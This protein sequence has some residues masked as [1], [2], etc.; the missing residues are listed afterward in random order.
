MA[1][2]PVL[3]V[4][5]I[6]TPAPVVPATPAPPRGGFAGDAQEQMRLRL[7]GAL[8]SAFAKIAEAAPA[9]PAAPATQVTPPATSTPEPLPAAPPE[10]A[11]TAPVV[12]ELDLE[13]I[14]LDAV[15]APAT[16]P[17]PDATP[18]IG[19]REAWQ[20]LQAAVDAGEIPEKIETAF[21]RTPRGKQMLTSFKTNRELQKP[22]E[23]GGIGTVPTVEEIREG[24]GFR[25]DVRVM[26]HEFRDNPTGFASNVLGLKV[27][28]GG[29]AVDG[30]SSYFGGPAE[31][32]QFLSSLPKVLAQHA[33]TPTGQRLID[34]YA[35]PIFK[36]FL[37][38]QYQSALALPATT[39][40]EQNLKARAIDAL[41]M[42]EYLR[43]GKA[44]PLNGVTA[45]A[46]LQPG[47]VS[48]EV[49]ELRA[50]AERAEQLL[51]QQ[52]N[53]AQGALVNQ[54]KDASRTSAMT[55]INKILETTGLSKVYPKE[56]LQPLV[57]DL[58]KRIDD[59]VTGASGTQFDR[60]GYQTY[61]IQLADLARD[62]NP[63]KPAAMYQRIFRNVLQTHPDIK[64]QLTAL[65]HNAK[66]QSDAKIGQQAAAQVRTEPVGN[67]SPVPTSVLPNGLQKNPGESSAEFNARRLGA[68]L[69]RSGAIR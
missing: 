5:D 35:T 10:P 45:P 54:V 32:E 33:N 63:S 36:S 40:Q 23:D 4:P 21:L 16:E 42:T 47:E 11:I 28:Q 69:A 65:V 61:Q 38:T 20:Q 59:L 30:I 1:T 53:T 67:G 31:V 17:A 50:R 15:V 60:S 52:R 55:D 26:R 22:W 13:A 58:Y 19:D 3:P 34:A 27:D 51:N 57:Q 29:N 48:P 8:G 41:Q 56:L 12:A 18:A 49:T 44:R 62:P 14:D 37:D 7:Q 9:T 39:E 25:N 6:Q 2:T 66:S 64:A 68:G 43:F 46:G 24:H